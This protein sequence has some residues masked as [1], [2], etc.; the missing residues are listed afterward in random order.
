MAS[1]TSNKSPFW[2]PLFF[3][4]LL[5][6]FLI[7]SFTGWGLLDPTAWFYRRQMRRRKRYI[8]NKILRTWLQQNAGTFILDTPPIG[9]GLRYVW[10]TSDNLPALAPTEPPPAK[11][12]FKNLSAIHPYDQWLWENYLDVDHGRALKVANWN[13][14]LTPEKLRKTFPHSDVIHTWSG[15]RYLIERNEPPKI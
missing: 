3:F 8:T 14:L 1:T 13:L 11:Y 12:Y 10:W 6:S 9:M 4:V 5:P 2:L 7:V 15:A